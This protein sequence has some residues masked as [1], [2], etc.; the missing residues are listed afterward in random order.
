VGLAR[1]WYLRLEL[2]VCGKLKSLTLCAYLALTISTLF[3]AGVG[4]AGLFQ[5]GS[6]L[7]PDDLAGIPA[8]PN[9]AQVGALACIKALN[10]RYTE[11]SPLK[12]SG[13]VH[14]LVP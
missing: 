7:Y 12:V 8:Y 10:K 13:R 6:M 14:T 9:G 2:N 5:I 4:L 1:P 3:R 11:S